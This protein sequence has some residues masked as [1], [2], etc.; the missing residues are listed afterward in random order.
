[1]KQMDFSPA[2]GRWKCLDDPH[3]L[4]MLDHKGTAQAVTFKTFYCLS[5]TSLKHVIG[6]QDIN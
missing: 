5:F 6:N 2:G 4:Y 1:M 3:L